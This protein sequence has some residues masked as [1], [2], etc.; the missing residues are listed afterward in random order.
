MTLV[1]LIRKRDAGHRAPAT[2]TPAIPAT[3]KAEVQPVVASVTTVAVAR[4]H[5]E[6]YEH[7]PTHPNVAIEPASPTPPLQPGWLV[8]Y[9]DRAMGPLRGL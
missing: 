4:P 2:A 5:R 3:R 7:M 8:V 1:E 6:N 9:R